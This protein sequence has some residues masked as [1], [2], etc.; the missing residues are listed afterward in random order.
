MLNIQEAGQNEEIMSSINDSLFILLIGPKKIYFQAN[1]II[2][3]T[4]T[5]FVSASH[6][7]CHRL[8]SSWKTDLNSS[9]AALEL[10]QGLAR[11]KLLEKGK[12]IKIDYTYISEI[13]FTFFIYDSPSSLSWPSS[14]SSSLVCFSLSSFFF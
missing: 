2:F 14:S 13:N 11:T 10:L 1:I 3:F 9:L 8:I 6:L 7:V 4:G 5:E 12:I